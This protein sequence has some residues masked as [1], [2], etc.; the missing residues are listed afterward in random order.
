MYEPT[1]CGMTAM[2]ATE[3][4]RADPQQAK[5]SQQALLGDDKIIGS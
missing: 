3:G 2:F 4:R 1:H 5:R